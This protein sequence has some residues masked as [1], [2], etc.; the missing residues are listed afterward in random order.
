LIRYTPFTSLLLGGFLLLTTPA[1]ADEI[2]HITVTASTTHIA[3]SDPAIDVSILETLFPETTVAGRFGGFTGFSERGTQP[4]HTL[5][6]RNG[7]PVND[8]G[9]GW[10]DFGHDL[11]T[12]N[13]TATIVTGTNSVLYGSGSLGGTVFLNDNINSGGVVRLGDQHQFVSASFENM[14]NL[15][16][17]DTTNKSVRN[18]NDETDDYK[19]ITARLNLE[20]EDWEVKINYTDYSYDFDQCWNNLGVYSNDCVQEGNKGTVS[21]RNDS[22]TIGYTFNDADYFALEDKT[23]SS[24]TNRY[25]ADHRQQ[26]VLT[27]NGKYVGDALVGVT[28]DKEEYAGHSQN[29][30]ALYGVFKRDMFELG[31]RV[32][33]DTAVFRAGVEYKKFFANVG[34]SYLN[35]TLYQLHGDAWVIPN[36]E[37]DP[38]EAIG[39]ELGYNKLSM[40]YYKFSQGIDYNFTDNQYVNTGNYDTKGVRYVDNFFPTDSLWFRIDAG[41]TDTDQPRVAKYKFVSSANYHFKKFTAK[42]TYTGLFDRKPSIYDGDS[43]KN[44][45]SFDLSIQREFSPEFLLS[46]TARDILDNEFEIVPGYDAGGRQLF[47]SLQYIPR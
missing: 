17:F 1:H 41:Y 27:N 44:I 6:Y 42:L 38:E 10:Y 46:L 24:R 13:E 32:T 47:L 22:T 2:E 16:Y 15:T 19:N 18:D 5:V 12:G 39:F 21:I 4:T 11:S 28:L 34:T 43:L 45:N 7:V 31:T 25:Y 14:F 37:L 35:P 23:W 40:F 36:T 3:T 30:V 9:A 33:N 20:V 8:A 29:N 26:Y